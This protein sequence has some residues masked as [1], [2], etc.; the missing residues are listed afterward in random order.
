MSRVSI[1][2][3]GSVGLIADVQ[4]QELP[5]SG[6]SDVLNIR[7][8]NGSAERMLGDRQVL[9]APSVTPYYL[10]IF[11]TADS[12]YMIHAGTGAVFADDGATR[13]DITGPALTGSIDNRWS[14]GTLNGVFVMNNGVD[15]PMYW[16]GNVATDLA[17]LTG[18]GATW[19]CSTLRPHKNYLVAL[20][21]T[22]GTTRY[23]TMVKW[24]AAADPGT[25]PASWDEAD[26]TIDAGEVDLADSPGV[27]IDAMPLGDALIIYKESS[28]YAM[29]YI[30]G[31]YIWQFSKL[32]GE[33]GMLA[34]GC[35]CL[36]PM[37][38]LVLTKGDVV[39]HA[40]QGAQSIVND[41]VRKWL[42]DNM[43]AIY[44]SRA[45]VV[46]NPAYSEAWICFPSGINSSCDKALVWNWS[47]NT[48][49]VRELSGVTYGCSGMFPITDDNTWAGDSAGWDSDAT[50]WS[51]SD[52]SSAQSRVFLCSNTPMIMASD[53]GSDF[54]GAGF[55]AKVER[56]G[57]A[58][59]AP[60][61][62]KVLRAIFPRIDGATGQTVY[63]QAGGA[64]DVEGPY[65]WS[66]PVPYVIGST[67]RADTFASGRFLAWRIY[68][69]GSFIWRIRS[70]DIDA[71][72]MGI[73]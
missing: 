17:T 7:L 36:V 19:K 25:I 58:L 45:F 1:P 70:I 46:S 2:S 71:A 60:D 28:M 63:V 29:S 41:K 64:M 33:S 55:T 22:K 52:L 66:D 21:I 56:V 53:I 59:G 30:G 48:F 15:K 62:V 44:F 18:W 72:P 14:G 51:Q 27:L 42:F 39:V 61:R 4:P 35:G 68:S 57:M 16:G 32:P 9:T 69:T 38:H 73:Y 11:S 12:K 37:G 40:G 65:A 10:Q 67:Y 20:D 43:S 50:T 24:S 5:D 8:R 13:T 47:D 54:H 23:P 34:R 49:S 31:Q 26:P 6:L 3:L